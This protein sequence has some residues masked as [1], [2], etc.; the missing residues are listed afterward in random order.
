[1]RGR[2]HPALPVSLAALLFLPAPLWA[3]APQT[4]VVVMDK[5]K[6]GP[7]P[8]K[9][10][11]GDTILWVNKDM[12]KHTATAKDGS[13]NVDL[14]AGAKGKTVLRKAGQ[15]PIVCKYHPAM[16]AVLKVA[17]K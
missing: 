3:A 13:F 9:A 8:A 10:R 4:H 7:L 11:V 17:P 16:R 5:M 15:I 6:F 14:A 12:F 2:V 1:M